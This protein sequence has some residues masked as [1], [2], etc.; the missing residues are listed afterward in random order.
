MC[1]TLAQ[2]SA[3]CVFSERP[4][5]SIPKV[6]NAQIEGRNKASYEPGETVSY[7]CDEG[8][9]IVGTPEIICR[10]GNWTAPPFCEGIGFTSK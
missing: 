5:G 6:A 1:I 7:Q 2:A 8:F 3:F 4:C 9:L 10:E